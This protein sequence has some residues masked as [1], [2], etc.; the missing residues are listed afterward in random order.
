MRWW[1]LVFACAFAQTAQAQE[2]EPGQPKLP[3][4]EPEEPDRDDVDPLLPEEWGETT[5][6][7]VCPEEADEEYN[8]AFDMLVRGLFDHAQRRLDF[9]I[10]MCPTHPHA[11]EMRRLAIAAQHLG[12]EALV[13]RQ[14][15]P[16]VPPPP[17]YASTQPPAVTRVETAPPGEELSLLAGGELA[18]G[19]TL[20]GFFEGIAFCGLV[21]CED[22]RGFVA[23]GLA[24][25]VVGA[26][27]S[28]MFAR[29]VRPGQ[30]LAINSGTAWGFWT[31]VAFANITE[32]RD[33]G[34]AAELM[35][36]ALLGTGVGAAVAATIKPRAGSV[37]LASSAGIWSGVLGAY[38]MALG[39]AD[40][41]AG[42]FFGAELVATNSGLLL[43]AL[44]GRYL[45]IS[46]GHVL[47]IDAGGIVGMLLG[48]GA[49]FLIDPEPSQQLVGGLA[50]LGTSGG[51]GG[52]AYLTR[53]FDAEGPAVALVPASPRGGYGMSL[54]L[55]F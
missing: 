29:S 42:S 51:L 49:A 43:G 55:D 24:G 4:Q 13:Q 34:A 52:V 14:M 5:T 9:A 27:I 18:L 16:P 7:T 12:T 25:S 53:D 38:A 6:S 37:S 36:F 31:F 20:H 32:P 44:A 15:P 41:S 2:E 1:P 17:R 35:T 30:A 11:A 54:A 23:A 10:A 40:L 48:V 47:L 28:A 45:P 39:G 19:Q 33:E 46:R 3:V 26:G 8:E 22:A 50:L 21:G